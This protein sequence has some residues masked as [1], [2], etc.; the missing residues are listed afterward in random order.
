MNLKG[1]E[2]DRFI[3]EIKKEYQNDTKWLLERGWTKT[4][5]IHKENGFESYIWISPNGKK[6]VHCTSMVC[7][8]EY[9][10]AIGVEQAEYIK[11]LGW[12]SI[13]VHHF[14]PKYSDC[15]DL[16][17]PIYV[18]DPDDVWEYYIHPESGKV[19]ML[20]EAVQIARYYNNK[21]QDFLIENDICGKSKSIQDG[22]G[23]TRLSEDDEICI[24]FVSQENGNYDWVVMDSK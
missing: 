1:E 10:Q 18:E 13:C 12:S 15:E 22:L 3:E 23:D 2:L 6:C 20:I 5:E 17:N 8:E 14:R 4:E 9:P 16:D 21:E 11:E 19:Y 24:K 7:F